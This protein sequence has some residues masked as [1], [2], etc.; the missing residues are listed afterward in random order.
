MPRPPTEV[1]AS[2]VVDGLNEPQWSPIKDVLLKIL[3]ENLTEY[4][5]N[6]LLELAEEVEPH[7]AKILRDRRDESILEGAV[8]HYDVDLDGNYLKGTEFPHLAL[9]T[10]L[11]TMNPFDFEHV[12]AKLLEKLGAK[13]HVTQKTNDGGVDFVGLELRPIP[14]EFALPLTSRLTVIGQAKRR[15]NKNVSLNELR[16]FVGA[17]RL[18]H[19]DL[20]KRDGIGVLS[21]TLLAYWTTSDFDSTAKIYA[22]D[23]GMWTLNGQTICDYI[24]KLGVTS[25]VPEQIGDGAH[26]KAPNHDD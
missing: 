11:R 26:S 16:Q 18:H 3:R 5:E 24:I 17:A 6:Q 9:L 4:T 12:C 7:I 23:I 21:P 1:I 20:I 25:L 19:D 10:R 14:V 8:V 22:R 15:S 2:W 13:A